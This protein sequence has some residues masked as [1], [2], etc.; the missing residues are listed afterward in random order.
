[1]S[2]QHDAKEHTG[3]DR[4]TFEERLQQ[5]ACQPWTMISGSTTQA[6]D[7]RVLRLRQVIPGRGW[8]EEATYLDFL[9]Q[10]MHRQL[11]DCFVLNA[12]QPQW[13]ID[14]LLKRIGPG[15]SRMMVE[16]ALL[17]GEM[18]GFMVA[19]KNR[20]WW[21]RGPQF[22][23]VYNLGATFE[24]LVQELLQRH[25]QALVRRRVLFKELPPHQFG[26]IDILAFTDDGL[27]VIIEC[28]SSSSGITDGHFTHF[29]NRASAFPADIALF[30][31]DTDDATALRNRLP[32]INTVL[33]YAL[34]HR[35]TAI[36]AEG[37]KIIY[38][39]QDNL[40]LSNTA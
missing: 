7:T 11:L 10:S 35:Y 28:K 37:S 13:Y 15:T 32:Q 29:I 14:E 23:Q 34:K 3:Q 24:W 16:T 5:C 26:D 1:M 2:E 12:R 9:D 31:I 40:Y 39:L 22:Q 21:S 17:F 38:H 8:C 30:L 18:Q 25:H 6:P 20:R 19:A 33:G 27:T 4:L 36:Y